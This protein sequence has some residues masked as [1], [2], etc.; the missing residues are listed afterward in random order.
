M[1]IN[2]PLQVLFLAHSKGDA[3]SSA[4][5]LSTIDETKRSFLL[6]Q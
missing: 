5:V 4:V 3:P 6:L 1:F 2:E